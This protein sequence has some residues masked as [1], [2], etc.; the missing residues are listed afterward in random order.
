[1]EGNP[2]CRFKFPMELVGFKMKVEQPEDG[3]PAYLIRPD[4]IP[5][6]AEEGAEYEGE[7]LKPLRNHPVIVH[8]IPEAL[9]VWGANIEGR[10]VES[11]QQVLKYLLKYMMKDEPN[12]QPFSAI[13][14]GVVENAQDD[15]PLRKAFQ[16]I[17]MKTVGQHDFSNQECAHILNGI[18]FVE[19]SKDCAVSR[20]MSWAP[21]N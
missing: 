11:Y 14:K 16:Q 18:E 6:K 4:R 1:M 13:C 9:V 12:S 17:L 20:S 7:K 3:G 19:M 5:G 2:V 21:T 15:S 8:H 10:V